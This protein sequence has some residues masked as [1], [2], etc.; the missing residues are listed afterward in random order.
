MIPINDIRGM[1]SL[2]FAKGEKLLRCKLASV[3]RLID[4]HG[5]TQNIYNHV[6]VS[7][8]VFLACEVIGKRK[9]E[10]SPKSC[11]YLSCFVDNLMILYCS[12]LFMALI[13]VFVFGFG[14]GTGTS[15]PGHRTFPAEPIWSAVS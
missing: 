11:D 14:F 15:E 4:M 6:T 13:I 5:W 12:C 2:S 10:R 7:L 8:V 3:Y 9:S 1:E